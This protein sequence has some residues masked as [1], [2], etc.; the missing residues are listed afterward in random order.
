VAQ[1]VA[2]VAQH[3]IFPELPPRPPIARGH[4]LRPEWRRQ[5]RLI[6][7]R[8]LT[9]DKHVVIRPDKPSW[10][11]EAAGLKVTPGDIIRIHILGG[12]N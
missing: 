9:T 1:W 11:C 10:S 4:E 7:C 8:N 3:L 5:K 12:A 6:V 2:R